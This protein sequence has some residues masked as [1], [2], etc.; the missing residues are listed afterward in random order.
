MK[1]YKLSLGQSLDYVHK[2][3]ERT[4]YKIQ[5]YDQVYQVWSN[6]KAMARSIRMQEK[7]ERRHD[8]WKAVV[9]L[10]E[11]EGH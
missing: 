9:K 7:R 1:T 3:S 11:G 10:S 6:R 5:G 8:D 4:A 2:A